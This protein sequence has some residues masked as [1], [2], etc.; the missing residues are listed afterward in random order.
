[1][2][3]QHIFGIGH[4]E[5]IVVLVVI[6]ILFGH[7]LPSIMRVLGRGIVDM[8][9]N[10]YELRREYDRRLLTALDGLMVVVLMV[11]VVLAAFV[12]LVMRG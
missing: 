10:P 4:T 9:M 7:R 1:M 5:I 2:R 12:L 8:K 6:F 11:V 3:S